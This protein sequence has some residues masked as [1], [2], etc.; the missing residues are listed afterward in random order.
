MLK[1]KNANNIGYLNS[2]PKFSKL[3]GTN[4]Y[5]TSTIF[6]GALVSMS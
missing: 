5:I 6:M 3:Y 2:Q 1:G 4:K